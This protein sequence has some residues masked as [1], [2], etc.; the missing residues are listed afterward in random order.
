MADPDTEGLILS[1]RRGVLVALE[2]AA[3]M[4][5]EAGRVEDVKEIRDQA[6]AFAH[7]ARERDLG[8]QASL[9]AAEIKVRAE[10]RLGELLAGMPNARTGRKP[11]LGSSAGPNSPPTLEEMGV[12]KMDSHRWQRMASVPV[13]AFEA[14]V[15]EA[16]RGERDLTSAGVGRLAAPR[17]E[18]PPAAFSGIIE[19]ERLGGWLRKQRES[20][21][22]EYRKDFVPFVRHLLDIIEEDDGDDR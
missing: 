7:Y 15:A 9:D 2:Q 1:E 6:M 4:I 18:P 17:P 19:A 14:H 13:E 20:W 12:T 21:P 10:R 22:A 8:R 5:A 3:R 11:E 16:R